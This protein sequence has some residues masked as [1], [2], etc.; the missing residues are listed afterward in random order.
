VTLAG[1]YEAGGRDTPDV[2]RLRVFGER[3]RPLEAELAGHT[4]G[5]AEASSALGGFAQPGAEEMAGLEEADSV[6]A[7]DVV[8]GVRPALAAALATPPAPLLGLD[9]EA[10]APAAEWTRAGPFAATRTGYLAEAGVPADKLE[11]VS[12]LLERGGVHRR[13][14]WAARV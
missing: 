12:V 6:A 3:A 11:Q 2:G 5:R 7:S 8:D 10:V 13:V 1:L 14:L 9:P 4:L